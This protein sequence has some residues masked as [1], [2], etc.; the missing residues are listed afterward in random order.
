VTKD[1][2]TTNFKDIIFSFEPTESCQIFPPSDKFSPQNYSKTNK[3]QDLILAFT[4]LEH[5]EQSS[6]KNN[7]GN[8]EAYKIFINFLK[9]KQINKTD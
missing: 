9:A 7:Q 4:I 1:N 3:L 2:L 6:V 8:F 5:K